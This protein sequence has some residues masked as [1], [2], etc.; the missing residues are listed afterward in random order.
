MSAYRVAIIGTGIPARS[1]HPGATGAA[2]SR[3]HARAYLNSSQCQIVALADIKPENA[4]AFKDAHHR[5]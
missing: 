2:M 1:G 5:I 4:Q 3:L